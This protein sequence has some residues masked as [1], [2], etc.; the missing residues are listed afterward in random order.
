MTQSTSPNWDVAI[1]LP[2]GVVASQLLKIEAQLRQLNMRAL[3]LRALHSGGP[4]GEVG[5]RLDHISEELDAIGRLV[6][7]MQADLR[8]KARPQRED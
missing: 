1:I 6:A 8:P 4:V 5:A 7:D 3:D 2:L